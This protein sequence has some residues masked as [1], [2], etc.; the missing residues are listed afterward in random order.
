MI[1]VQRSI[2]R[3][4]SPIRTIFQTKLP[5]K[6]YYYVLGFISLCLLI[7]G[8]VIFHQFQF[9]WDD[10]WV[11]MNDYTEGGFNIENIVAIL[12]EFYHGQY[13]PVNQL[14]YLTLY[15]LF[16]YNALW[17]HTASMG[18][19]I[20]NVILLFFLIKKLLSANG[21]FGVSK[22]MRISLIT[23]LLMVLHPLMTE[24]V[25]WMSASK[26]LLFTLFYLMALHAYVNYLTT[27]KYWHYI[28][29]L[30]FFIF[31]F[32]AK[33]QAVTLP[34]C[35]LLFDFMYKRDLQQANIWFEKLPFFCLSICFGIVTFYS[36]AFNG[37]G[38][39]S[40]QVHY[41]V[42]ENVVFG[43]YT[44]I[45]YLIKIIL[46]LKLHYIYPFPYLP[47]EPLPL[48]LLIYP[49]LLIAATV[50][51]WKFWSKKWVFFGV[52]FYLIQISIV[53]NV[54]PT[55]RFAIIADRYVYLPSIGIFFLLAY[56]LDSALTQN[57]RLRTV[58]LTGILAYFVSLS[59]YARQRVMVW[60]D[61][62][63]LKKELRENLHNRA[64]YKNWVKKQRF[65]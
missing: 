35:L 7:Y 37:E 10:Q 38:M 2:S 47:G 24:S 59:F 8:P 34:L 60:Q 23:S 65:K 58:I 43:A 45:E 51:F 62:F 26:C 1:S 16:G 44:V 14:F 11:V 31:S 9:Y 22:V 33:E 20:F 46:P 29:T 36:Q 32:G 55:S 30:L 17:F 48:Y 64:D 54:I 50:T 6:N 49:V 61:S 39:L 42:Y 25:C 53:S 41:K 27:K 57:G 12:T 3:L 15:N 40:D 5:P 28:L 56:L 19:H 18:I 63:T 4:N 52:A 21:Q 13:A